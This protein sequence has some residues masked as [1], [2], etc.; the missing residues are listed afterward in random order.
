MKY[1]PV[2]LIVVALG[3][4]IVP[5]LHLEQYWTSKDEIVKPENTYGL[6]KVVPPTLGGDK[7]TANKM[8]GMC[9]AIADILEQDT[10]IKYCINILDLR[11]SAWAYCGKSVNDSH[12]DF[13]KV[14][15][16]VFE[17]ELPDGSAELTPELRKKSVELFRALGWACYVGGK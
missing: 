13:A 4:V 15:Q 12:P 10:K 2:A 14:V 8:S 6:D 9:Y 1:I 17:K 11:K 16:P 5:R 7:E 3:L